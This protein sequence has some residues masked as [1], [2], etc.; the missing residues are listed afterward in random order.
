MNVVRAA[1]SAVLGLGAAL[2]L[3]ATGRV[4]FGALAAGLALSAA[5]GGAAYA[6]GSL[7]RDG[8]LGAALV[9]TATFA[10]GGAAWGL[11]LIVFFVSSSALSRV[12]LRSR[13]KQDAAEAFAK[14]GRRDLGQV[15]ANGGTAALLAAV[16]AAAPPGW[17]PALFAACAGS[18]AAVTADTWGTELGVLSRSTP[19]LITTGRPVPPGTSGGV[20]GLGLGAALLG[21]GLIGFA[22]VA[23]AV[24]FPAHGLRVTDTRLPA[25]ALLG[26]LLGALADSLLG[27]TVQAVMWCPVCGKQT[28]RRVHSCGTPT[29]PLRGWAWVDNEA[30]NFGCSLV[31]AAGGA[32]FAWLWPI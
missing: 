31:G 21:A 13:R 18:L 25:A 26:G 3:L 19:R 17:Q 10:F 9:G 30:V 14:G 27:A 7:T 8:V 15:L 32:A 11:L 5:V 29:L 12:G 24:I 4:E 20:S 16:S 23:L 1:V 2:L 22:A 28:E 6:A